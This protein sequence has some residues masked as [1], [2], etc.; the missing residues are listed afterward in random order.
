MGQARVDD[1]LRAFGFDQGP[2]PGDLLMEFGRLLPVDPATPRLG[3]AQRSVGLHNVT[4]TPLHAAV[5]AAALASDGHAP[6]PHLVLS[7]AALGAAE[8]YRRAA[9]GNLLQATTP[10]ATAAI[11]RAMRTVVTA[12]DGT[13]RRAAIPGLDFAMKT[14][15]AGE[16]QPGFNSVI[17]GYAP[18]DRPQ[19]AFGF[20]AERAGKAELEGARIVRDFLATVRSEFGDKP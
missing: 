3:L 20:V 15:T 6:R 12:E 9:P 7:V 8:P 19:V 1:A 4:I 16:R 11:A 17:F 13:G 5:I 14:G 10:A 2:P 18:L